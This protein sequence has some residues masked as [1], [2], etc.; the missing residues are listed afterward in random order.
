MRRH[1]ILLA[2]ASAAA[3]PAAAQSSVTL[4]GVADVGIN[5]TSNVAGGGLTELR[6][7]NILTSR[8]G[9]RGREDL[10]NGLAA[11]FN[12]ESGFNLDS[13][14]SSSATTFFNRQSWVGLSADGIG[15]ITVG[16]QLPTISDVFVAYANSTFMGSQT[17]ALD[18]GATAAGS[19]AARFN[20]LIGG[21][22]LANMIKIKSASFAGFSLSAMTVPGE[23]AGSNRAGRADSVGLSYNQGP[24]EAGIAY[25]R[26]NCPEVTGCPADKA[27]DTLAGIGASY[28]FGSG[29]RVGAFFTREKNAKNVL[30]SNADVV[31]LLAVVPIGLFTILAGYQGLN[32]KSALDQ[33]VKQVNL[34]LK[35]S[36]SKRTDLYTLY[37]RQTV[38][39]GGKAGMFSQLSSNG[40]QN[41]Y[42]IGIRHS[43]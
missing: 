6:S 20:N 3:M 10:G 35:Y 34:G 31:S 37:S 26:T 30:H 36:L 16:L 33:D 2:M 18:G 24:V 7:G 38:S 11:I 23:V 1:Y 41:Q 43:F 14:T 8:F 29:G 40:R 5:Y 27:A 17:A 21:T 12:L 15:Q 9:F 25:Q 39:N 42:N 4:Y 28:K 22:R 32:D 19:S 13:G